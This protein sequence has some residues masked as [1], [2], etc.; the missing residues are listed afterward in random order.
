MALQIINLKTAPECT[1]LV[2]DRGLRLRMQITVSTAPVQAITTHQLA[3]VLSAFNAWLNGGGPDD[4]TCVQAPH[5]LGQ[6][7]DQLS[8]EYLLTINR[9]PVTV[10][11][12][13]VEWF[14][15]ALDGERT[16]WRRCEPSS[17]DILRVT[18]VL[19][20]HALCATYP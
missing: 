7:S 4:V 17:H 8:R 14:D 12:H 20:Y 1:W 2:E 19:A 6:P 18:P 15:V 9:E 10:S 5:A 16:T 3:G 13:W 11:I